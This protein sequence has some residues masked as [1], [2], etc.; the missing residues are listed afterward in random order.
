[1]N[2]FLILNKMSVDIICS[3]CQTSVSKATNYCITLCNHEFHTSCLFKIK[4][5]H[6]PSCRLKLVRYDDVSDDSCDDGP[7]WR[8]SNNETGNVS[9]DS[10]D[11]GPCWRSSNNETGYISD[12]S[13]DNGP[14]WR[15]SND[16]TGYI[17]DDSRD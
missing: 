5:K 1:M 6:C 14:C 12:D 3:I 2:I 17:S 7:W 11:D 9:D 13:R 4:S 10:R 8:P 16:K 15:S